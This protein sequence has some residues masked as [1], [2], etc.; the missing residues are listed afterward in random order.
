MFKE[1]YINPESSTFG[2]A[3]QSALAAGYTQEY[4]ESITAKGN[5]WMAEIV[6]DF[7]RYRLADDVLTH[8]LLEK[9]LDAAKFV[10]KNKYQGVQK[11]DLTSGGEKFSLLVDYVKT[12][13]SSIAGEAGTD[14]STETL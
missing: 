4:S 8:H 1:G 13:K 7:E 2:N 14:L 12:D 10:G 3:M 11:L 6:G 5:E 9:N